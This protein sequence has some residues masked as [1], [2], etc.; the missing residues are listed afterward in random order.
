MN[1]EAIDLLI[2]RNPKLKSSRHALERMVAGTFCIH[3]SWGFGKIREYD[4]ATN[5][6]IIDF[7]DGKKATRWTPPSVSIS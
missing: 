6:L 2:E 3:R 4:E 1:K 7:Q 5:K